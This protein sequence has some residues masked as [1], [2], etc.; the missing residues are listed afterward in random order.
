MLTRITR[1]TLLVLCLLVAGV[2]GWS[3]W[4]LDQLA[5]GGASTYAMYTNRGSLL[6]VHEKSPPL[7][8]SSRG[9]KFSQ[10][11]TF[12]G[13][14]QWNKNYRWPGG[15]Y[16]IEEASAHYPTSVLIVPMRIILMGTALLTTA[17]WYR[18]IRN[19][20]R[21]KRDAGFEVEAKQ[22]EPVK[23]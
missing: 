17:M 8:D 20:L 1:Y 2:W 19:R 23:E 4:R 7:S 22:L 10:T 9:F 11:A 12:S 6:L 18:P 13:L 21:G 5:Y 3:Y 14:D 15:I 16:I